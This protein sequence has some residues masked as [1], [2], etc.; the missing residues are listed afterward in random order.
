MSG[1]TGTRRGGVVVLLGAPGAAWGRA[2]GGSHG[3]GHSSGGH[4]SSSG[5]SGG[6]YGGGGGDGDLSFGSFLL[7]L[8]VVLVAWMV[9]RRIQR[10]REA[11]G[12]GPRATAALGAATGAAVLGAIA[13]AASARRPG[14]PPAV[15]TIR[16]QDPGFELETFLQRAEMSFFLVTRGLERN[17]PA[18][19]RPYVNDALLAQLTR[20]IEQNR[21]QHRHVLLESLNVRAVHLVDAACDAQG[22]RLEVHFDLVY[23]AKALD[24]ANRVVTDEGDDRRR[25]ERWTFVRAADARTPTTGDVTAS[26]CPACGAELKLSLDGLCTHCRASVTNG[27]VDWVVSDIR[28]APFIGFTSDSQLAPAAPTV[29]EGVTALRAA[30]PAF[31]P[32]AF[33]T[34]VRSAFL[35]L[36]QA[37]CQQNLDAG[38]A[39]LSPGA[40]FAWRAQLEV[41]AAEGRRNVMEQL[42][43]QRIEPVRIVHGRVYDDLTVR[44]TAACADYET[45]GDGRVVF[46]D[47][48]VRPFSELW[49]FQRSVGVTTSGKPGTLENTCP[50]CGA[51]V[52]LTQIGE[53]RYCKAAVTS[54]KFDWVVS[55]IEQEDDSS[56][57]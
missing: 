20:R 30:D 16:A 28:P 53:C 38:R 10:T 22:Q 17:D 47:R 12:L 57:D 29:A 5:H 35:A 52:A 36:Q 21:S 41:M 6:H 37:W 23:R 33:K 42:E 1:G 32:D 7:L 34:R 48:T 44:I 2:G 40:Y 15:A 4:S 43:V 51:P 55:R 13:A 46:G 45:D 49:T 19:I 50:S 8:I 3:G 26:R 27:S 25:A 18:A 11:Q 14:V 54:G 31:S 39:F 9:L 56:D 24:D